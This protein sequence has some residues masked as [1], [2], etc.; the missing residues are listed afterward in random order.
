MDSNSATPIGELT[1]QEG[2]SLG[3]GKHLL[4]VQIECSHSFRID[5]ML[6]CMLLPRNCFR[7]GT[8]FEVESA[9]VVPLF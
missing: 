1:L 4:G 8:T 9:N 3:K 5:Y 6:S 2:S 7:E